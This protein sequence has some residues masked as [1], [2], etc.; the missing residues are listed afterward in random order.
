MMT[1]LER[2]RWRR[3]AIQWVEPG[4]IE[5]FRRLQ[6][7]WARRSVQLVDLTQQ[8]IVDARAGALA[9]EDA[10]GDE[11]S[12]DAGALRE[13]ADEVRQ[14]GGRRARTNSSATAARSSSGHEPLSM[15]ST[16]FLPSPGY[17]A[18]EYGLS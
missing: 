6:A 1:G 17:P 15:N 2:N 4:M 11:L 7:R 3:R 14:T 10:L 8:R 16:P 12:E 13:D 5:S 9:D 18:A